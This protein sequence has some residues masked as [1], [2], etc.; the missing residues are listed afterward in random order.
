[1]EVIFRDNKIVEINGARIL[2]PNFE[3]REG[4]FNREGERSFNVLI[5]TEEIADSLCDDVNEDGVG[6]NVKRREPRDEDDT[7]LM[8]LPVKVR[9]NGRGPKIYLDTNGRVNLLDEDTVGILDNI[10]ISHVDMDIRP[11]DNFVNDKPYRT[12]YLQSM[13]V[14]QNVDRFAERYAEEE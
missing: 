9:F 1:M 5:P 14:Y 11:F 13:C 3:G 7:P 10:D 4:K 2:W 12:A 6:W 8:F